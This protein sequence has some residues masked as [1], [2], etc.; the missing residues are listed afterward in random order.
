MA[1]CNPHLHV[2]LGTGDA[3]AIR[4]LRDDLEE[5]GGVHHNQEV[6]P[7]SNSALDRTGKPEGRDPNANSTVVVEQ[8]L[9]LAE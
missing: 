5:S 9:E 6:L 2:D 3:L 1:S 4:P 8:N 7:R